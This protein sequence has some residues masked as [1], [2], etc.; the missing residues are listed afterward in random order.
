MSLGRRR[1]QGTWRRY[2][3][4]AVR[5]SRNRICRADQRSAEAERCSALRRVPECLPK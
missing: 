3:Y 5:R 1:A 2:P 4:C